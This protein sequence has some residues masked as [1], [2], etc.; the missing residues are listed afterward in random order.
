MTMVWNDLG[1]L[2]IVAAVLC[3]IGF[4]KYVYFL[5]VGYGLAI[6]GLG[7][8]IL[9][10]FHRQAAVVNAVQCLIFTAYGARLSGF[11]ITRE[12]RSGAYRKTLSSTTAAGAGMAVYV[13]AAIWIS[14][15]VLYVMQVSPVFYRLYNGA[16]DV[17]LPWIGIAVS[18][19]ALCIETLADLQK[20]A[21]KAVNPDMV[22]TKGLY[23]M[24]RCPNY[25][26]EVLFWTGVTLGGLTA[27]SGWAQW[28]IALFAYAAIVAIMFNGAQR[29]EKRQMARYG[30][31]PAYREYTEKTPILLP[32]V[33][34]Y[35]LNKDG[36]TKNA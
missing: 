12:I 19:C 29:L 32:L 21:Q 18:L 1:I 7:I 26:G 9:T 16:A 31:L 25:F 5:S 33:P 6:A 15:S 3:A 10:L 2:F 28:V 8:A 14:M 27:L 23:R 4:Y 11:L 34:L 36:Q 24:V 13:K 17:V 20:S 35:H 30:S 22:A